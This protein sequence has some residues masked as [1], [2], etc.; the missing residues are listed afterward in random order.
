MISTASGAHCTWSAGGRKGG[1]P[2]SVVGRIVG[3]SDALDGHVVVSGH[4]DVVFSSTGL[5]KAAEQVHVRGR[6]VNDLRG[7]NDRHVHVMRERKVVLHG[8]SEVKRSTSV[9]ISQLNV[10]GICDARDAGNVHWI[11]ATLHR[12]LVTISNH[13]AHTDARRNDFGVRRHFAGTRFTDEGIV[14]EVTDNIE[15]ERVPFDVIVRA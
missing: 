15:L 8:G 9:E 1:R 6:P 12:E 11:Q 7:H 4:T 10:A 2:V 3:W 14:L 5:G 13:A